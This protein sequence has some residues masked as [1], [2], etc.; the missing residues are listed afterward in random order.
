MLRIYYE[1]PLLSVTALQ[2]STVLRMAIDHLA[3]QNLNLLNP[4]R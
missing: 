1:Q 2:G 3:N 4:S